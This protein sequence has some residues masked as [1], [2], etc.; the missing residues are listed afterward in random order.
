MYMKHKYVYVYTYTCLRALLITEYIF[1]GLQRRSD[2][3][4]H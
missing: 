1:F 2:L 3:K 4:I